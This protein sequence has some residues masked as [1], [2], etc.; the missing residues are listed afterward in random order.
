[1]TGGNGWDRR[2]EYYLFKSAQGGEKVVLYVEMACNGMF[3]NGLN[4][5]INPPDPNRMFTL[6]TC[7]L[8]VFDREAFE[9]Y[10]DFKII[11]EMAKVCF[12]CVSYM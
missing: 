4:G 12:A 9:L 1:M 6:K 3:G 2:V 5:Q 11:A 8:R 7:E 10:M